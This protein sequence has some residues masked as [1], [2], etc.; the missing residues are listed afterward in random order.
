MYEVLL[1]SL[2]LSSE[3]TSPQSCSHLSSLTLTMTGLLT[4]R[5]LLTAILVFQTCILSDAFVMPTV[6][7]KL[8]SSTELKAT[9]RRQ[10]L[11]FVGA[12]FILLPTKPAVAAYGE[13][14]NMQGFD[15]I[16]YL[17]EKNAVADSST[18]LYKGADRELQLKRI[19]DAIIQLQKIPDIASTKK[20]SQVQGIL[21][22]PL[23]TLLQT[24]NQI[25]PNPTAEQKTASQKV[26]T[27]LY[28]I[29]TAATKKS[30]NG[31]L[32]ATEAALKDLE[33]FV[34]VAF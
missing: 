4:R 3:K 19:K 25:I 22:G 7:I 33:A 34:K 16:D 27:D 21:T 12:A 5:L 6:S 30:E 9:R 32:E 20:W 26:K 29:G 24:M 14:T 23:G 13:A 28:A 2:L 8:D 31:C 1:P 18:F 17:M 11:D 15:Y 10:M